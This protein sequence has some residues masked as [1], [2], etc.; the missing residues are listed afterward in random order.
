MQYMVEGQASSVGGTQQ[1]P[2][3][4]NSTSR[5]PGWMGARGVESEVG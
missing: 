3:Q 5:N 1:H 4:R 2:F